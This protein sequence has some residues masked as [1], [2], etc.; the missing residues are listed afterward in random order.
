MGLGVGRFGPFEGDK[1]RHMSDMQEAI[2][3]Q[4]AFGP[5]DLTHF[6]KHEHGFIWRGGKGSDSECQGSL[7][8]QVPK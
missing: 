6:K 7:S 4:Q 1:Y 3:A 8:V 2:W 5:P